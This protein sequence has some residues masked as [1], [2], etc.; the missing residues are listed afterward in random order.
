MVDH[1]PELIEAGIDSFKVEGRMKNALYIASV[2]RAYRRAIDDFLE[3]PQKYESNREWYRTEVAKC[4]VRPFATGFFFGRPDEGAQIYDSNTYINSYTL[5]GVVDEI[6]GDGE[7]VI[8]QKNKF[9]LNDEIEIV[10]PDFT[11][12][13]ARV[14]RI[15]DD[16]GEEAE[17]APHPGQEL[18]LR[19]NA[20]FGRYDVLRIRNS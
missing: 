10:H 16:K 7:A 11:S 17:S 5:L 1:I 8:H 3:S 20:P 9:L 4:T 6:S 2:T 14:E 12:D 15:I 19:L 18:R 13:F